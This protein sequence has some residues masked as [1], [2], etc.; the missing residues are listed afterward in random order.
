[1]RFLT[2]R[3]FRLGTIILIIGAI[4]FREAVRLH[5]DRPRESGARS[6]RLDSV[7]DDGMQAGEVRPRVD[8]ES[9]GTGTLFEVTAAITETFAHR[10]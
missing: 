7:R 1:M 2:K 10:P 3:R 4:S 5:L 6:G 9:L 8:D